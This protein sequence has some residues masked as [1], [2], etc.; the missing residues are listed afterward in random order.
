MAP[1]L[2]SGAAAD[3]GFSSPSKP[4]LF[5]ASNRDLM[6]VVQKV[7]SFYPSFVSQYLST[8]TT[9]ALLTHKILIIYLHGPFSWSKI[10]FFGPFTFCFDFITL[11]FLHRGLGSALRIQ[12]ICAVFVSIVIVMC[13][14][15]FVSV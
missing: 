7:R 1:L 12:R 10:V 11:R 5:F 4:L 15:T 9:I 13:S 2:P 6:A 3:P 8:V 14:A